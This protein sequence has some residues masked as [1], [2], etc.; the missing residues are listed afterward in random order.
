M[1]RRLCG[2][3]VVLILCV[4]LYAQVQCPGSGTAA[5]PTGPDGGN[6]ATGSNIPFTWTAATLSPVTYDILVGP[7]VNSL[8]VACSNQTGTNCSAAINTAGQYTWAV[9]TKKSSCSDFISTFKPFTVGC[10]TNPPALQ[11][12]S[13]NAT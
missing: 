12:P 5:Q 1:V 8:T 3:A 10:L 7:N 13:D 4:P 2:F 11:S 9:K 6:F